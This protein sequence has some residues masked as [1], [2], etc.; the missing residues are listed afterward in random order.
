MSESIHAISGLDWRK[1]VIDGRTKMARAKGLGAIA[2]LIQILQ[3]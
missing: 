2:G 3:V 1:Q